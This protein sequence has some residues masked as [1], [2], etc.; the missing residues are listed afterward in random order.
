MLLATDLAD[1]LVKSGMPFRHAH[2]CVGKAVAESLRSGIPLDQLDFSAL[3]PAFGTDA[4]AVFSLERALAARSNL[5]SP[6][7]ANVRAEIQRWQQILHQ[8]SAL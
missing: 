1:Y 2:E 8:S 7:I 6:S 3:D 5:G 4:G